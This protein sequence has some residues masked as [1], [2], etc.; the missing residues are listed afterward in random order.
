ML[1]GL[2]LALIPFSQHWGGCMVDFTAVMALKTAS[3]AGMIFPDGVGV[4]S[5]RHGALLACVFGVGTM[6]PVRFLGLVKKHA[7]MCVLWEICWC[8]RAV[9]VRGGLV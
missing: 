1:L 3:G 6:L 4:G 2:A 9:E 7:K 5:Q 8:Q